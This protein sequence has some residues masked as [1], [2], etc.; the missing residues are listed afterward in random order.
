MA[1][2]TAT[3]IWRQGRGKAWLMKPGN[4]ASPAAWLHWS[5]A[6]QENSG[7]F[8]KST[9]DHEAPHDYGSMKLA[10]RSQAKGDF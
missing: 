10:L 2:T 1:L 7:Y 3:R 4:P 6:A 5:N 8:K 9:Q